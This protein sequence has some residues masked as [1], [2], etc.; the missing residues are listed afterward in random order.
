M[1]L[2]CG[3]TEAILQCITT[4]YGLGMN[5]RMVPRELDPWRTEIFLKLYVSIFVTYFAC[6]MFV[7]LSL[8]A[9]YRK[10]SPDNR[11]SW[12][13]WAMVVIAIIFGVGSMLTALMSCIPLTKLW[14][15]S[16]PGMCINIQAFYYANGGFM[17]V[18]DIVLYILPILIVR[19]VQ[20]SKA[21]RAAMNVLFALGFIVVVSSALRMVAIHNLFSTPLFSLYYQA[22]LLIWCTVENHLALIIICLPAVKAAV[23][24]VTPPMSG[25]SSSLWSRMLGHGGRK[26]SGLPSPVGQSH[27]SGSTGSSKK[28]KSWFS[29]WTT[30][31]ET[32][33]SRASIIA[34]R[35]V[36]R[37]SHE[38]MG[39]SDEI[40]L[41][42]DVYV[43]VSDEGRR[44]E[45]GE[46]LSSPR[47]FVSGKSPV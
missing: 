22:Q 40:E 17:I 27:G 15:P 47:S 35:G 12:L 20:L 16:L 36:S 7:K 25:S 39:A 10:L 29:D 4:R 32:A 1:A 6:N 26:S 46:S 2:A 13:I 41:R 8:L 30:T 23:V 38:H 11:Y 31:D 45:D 42:K 28:S 34:G 44:S 18:T 37:S 21:K 9:F 19:G 14:H 3:L 24:A 5:Q 33:K 43:H